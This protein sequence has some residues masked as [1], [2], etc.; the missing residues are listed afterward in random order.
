MS[1]P[2]LRR[3]CFCLSLERGGILLCVL[4]TIICIANIIV[5]SWGLPRHLER[6]QEDNL[7]SMTSVMF[8]TLSAISNITA[9]FG[10]ILRR[11]GWLQMSILFNSVFILCLFLVAVVT[12]IFSYELQPYLDSA[13]SIALIV[14]TIIVGAAYS[15]YYL[16]VI[17]SLYRNMKIMF[18]GSSLPM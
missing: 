11:P 4:S 6:K 17:N 8:A 15:I 2:M 10:I 16:I 3:C 18:G 5:G 14:I 7:I 9:L 1:L 13:G 12:C